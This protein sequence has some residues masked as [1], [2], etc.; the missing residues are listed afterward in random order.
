MTK[1]YP[2]MTPAFPPLSTLRTLAPQG[3]FCRGCNEPATTTIDR[4]PYCRECADSL[5]HAFSVIRATTPT[6]VRRAHGWDL[7]SHEPV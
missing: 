3:S 1:T 7:H 4:I 6:E 2:P 5:T